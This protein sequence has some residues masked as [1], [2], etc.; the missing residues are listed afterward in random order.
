MF[1]PNAPNLL[2]PLNPVEMFKF[3]PPDS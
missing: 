2:D 3:I 1:T